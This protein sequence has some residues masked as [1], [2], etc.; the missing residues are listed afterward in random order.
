MLYQKQLVGNHQTM[1]DRD[2]DMGRRSIK[3]DELFGH[4][5]FVGSRQSFVVCLSIHPI[6]TPTNQ[7]QLP[8]MMGWGLPLKTGCIFGFSSWQDEV[9]YH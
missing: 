9:V 8:L 6:R 5:P 3:N 1:Y 2:G 7:D 4:L